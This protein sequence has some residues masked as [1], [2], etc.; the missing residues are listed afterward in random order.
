M[1]TTVVRPGLENT[2]QKQSSHTEEERA[3]FY[4]RLAEIQEQVKALVPPGVSLADELIA[5]RRA[6]AR[7]EELKW[8]QAS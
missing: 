8:G 1:S 5:E 4:R 7:R 6:E 2:D 3:A